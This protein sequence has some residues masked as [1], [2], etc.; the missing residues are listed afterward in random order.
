MNTTDWTQASV[1]AAGSVGDGAWQARASV[2]TQTYDQTFSAVLAGRATERL[3]FEQ[4]IPSSFSTGAAQWT[5]GTSTR[6]WL[7]GVE[8]KRTEATVEELRYSFAGVQ[9]GPFLLGGTEQ[10]GA[11]FA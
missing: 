2:G 7:V 6:V 9:S 5:R 1:E 11:M 4:S 3:T 8:A 10:S